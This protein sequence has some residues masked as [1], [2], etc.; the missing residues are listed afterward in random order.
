MSFKKIFTI[1]GGI[2]IFMVAI[3]A[4]YNLV[5]KPPEKTNEVILYYGDTCP[6]CK[7]VEEYLSKNRPVE[8]KLNLIKKEVYKNRDNANDLGL[9]AEICRYYNPVG[10]PVPFFYNKGTCLVGDKPIIDF[11]KK[12]K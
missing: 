8:K 7:I 3:G 5:S 1:V 6:H 2:I 10:I 11:F 9:K 12:I 4:I